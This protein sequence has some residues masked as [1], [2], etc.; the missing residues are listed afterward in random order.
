M[1][2]ECKVE[3]ETSEGQE[4]PDSFEIGAHDKGCKF[5]SVSRS[6]RKNF[7]TITLTK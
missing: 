5:S 3:I 6:F 1:L 7:N 2:D 4:L